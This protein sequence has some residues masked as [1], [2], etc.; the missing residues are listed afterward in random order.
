MRGPELNTNI[1]GDVW[2][3][4]A[5]TATGS[6][7]IFSE[8]LCLLSGAGTQWDKTVNSSAFPIL[9]II[10]TPLPSLW[11][12]PSQFT[13]PRRPDYIVIAAYLIIIS[14]SCG[15]WQFPRVWPDFGFEVYCWLLKLWSWEPLLTSQNPQIFLFTMMS[16]AGCIWYSHF[17]LAMLH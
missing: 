6:F 12:S 3:L 9:T 10:I 13:S 4:H 11:H 8:R 15:I 17:L 1:C 2:F 16:L 7:I 5:V 14:V